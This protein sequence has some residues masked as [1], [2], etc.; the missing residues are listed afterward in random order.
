MKVK[1]IKKMKFVVYKA[2]VEKKIY[3]NK[4]LKSFTS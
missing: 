3:N 4:I 1:P 2:L